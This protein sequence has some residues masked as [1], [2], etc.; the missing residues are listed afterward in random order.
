MTLTM[1]RFW[2][3]IDEFQLR[4]LPLT[5]GCFT[6]FG[7]LNNSSS[8]RL[9]RF[10]VSEDWESFFNGLC[11]SLPPSPLLIMHLFYWMEEESE[12]HLS[13]QAKGTE[14]GSQSTLKIP[15]PK[16]GLWRIL[17]NGQAWK[18]FP[19]GKS[20]E[21][22]L[23]KGDKSSRF[24]HKMANAQRRR[25]FL[26]TVK[27]NGRRLTNEDEIREEVVNTFHRILSETED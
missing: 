16:E 22:W 15:R 23:R 12:S 10:L 11:Q 24:F 4:D 2:E 6:W 20:R 9:D 5:G 13:L 17:A 25:N 21:V 27:V 14:A 1:R 26:S 8:S 7:G 3:I 19:R 18:R